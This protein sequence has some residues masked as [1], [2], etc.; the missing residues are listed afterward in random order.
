ML[1]YPD[2]FTLQSI[3]GSGPYVELFSI[4]KIYVLCVA[5]ALGFFLIK[6]E[7]WHWLLLGILL[8]MTY[9]TAASSNPRLAIMGGH[10][11]RD[12]TLQWFVAFL[13][14]LAV[15]KLNFNDFPKILKWVLWGSFL[16]AVFG[17]LQ[18]AG[19]SLADAKFIASLIPEVR[20][21]VIWT[22]TNIASF[23][24]TPNFAGQYFATVYAIGLGL[25]L[26]SSSPK[27]FHFFSIFALAGLIGSNCRSASM[28]LAV[29]LILYCFFYKNVFRYLKTL[30][31]HITTATVL[32]LISNPSRDLKF[33]R[34]QQI[35]LPKFSQEVE[36]IESSG[37]ELLWK[38]NGTTLRI[39][40]APKDGILLK[41]AMGFP[42]P[43]DIQN[44]EI[45]FLDP[46][47]Q[48][49]RMT[50]GKADKLNFINLSLE[51]L[52][53]KIWVLPDRFVVADSYENKSKFFPPRFATG[54][55]YIWNQTLDLISQCNV[56]GCDAGSFVLKF[57]H[58]DLVGRFNAIDNTMPI[59]DKPHSIWLGAFY[60][61]GIVLLSFLIYLLYQSVKGMVRARTILAPDDVNTYWIAAACFVFLASSSFI[62]PFPS[63]I[64]LF[65]CLF[66][67]LRMNLK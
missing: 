42:I 47:F 37:D 49:I 43:I 35:E 66:V 61:Y 48:N 14:P 9:K 1:T 23:F 4:S 31:F 46:R 54:R 30:A 32:V 19:W 6:I 3:F 34:F 57:P 25:S 16:P 20:Y 55:G 40:R 17:L 26:S 13:F 67:L 12:G 29:P 53:I 15:N 10:E 41:D 59:V 60:N 52:I 24:Y 56:A 21:A 36:A 7:K 2:N 8:W 38:T 44:N 65:S 50:T 27:T 28:A 51:N 5:A 63:N 39:T 58:H 62:D 33:G 11:H 22:S 64:A 45:R 18:L